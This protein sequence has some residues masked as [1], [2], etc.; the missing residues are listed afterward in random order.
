MSYVVFYENKNNKFLNYKQAT[1]NSCIQG[2][3]YKFEY[4]DNINN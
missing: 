3:I 4:K 1:K 2:F